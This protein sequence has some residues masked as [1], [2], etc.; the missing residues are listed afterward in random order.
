MKTGRAVEIDEELYSNE[1]SCI[2]FC[3]YP[4]NI[5]EGPNGV[6]R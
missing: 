5:E 4:D 3:S 1:T 2:S 6:N